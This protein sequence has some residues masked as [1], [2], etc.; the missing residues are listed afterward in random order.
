[1]RIGFLLNHYYL[2]Q[3][4]H[5]VPYAFEL[6]RSYPDYE[7]TIFSST[8]EEETYA[9]DIGRLYPGHR[10]KFE[11][12]EIP[13]W[14][15]ALEPAVRN[16]F[17]LRKEF[18]LRA[19]IRRFSKLDAIVSP[20]MTCLSLRKHLCLKHLKLIFTGHGAGDNRKIGSFDQRISKFDLALL[21]GKKYASALLELGYL[22]AGQYAIAGYPKFEVTRKMGNGGRPLFKNERPVVIY[23]PHHAPH[24]T[25]WHKFGCDVLD[26]FL[27][28]KDYNLIFAPHVVLFERAWSQGAR[29]PRKYVSTDNV[30]IDLGSR[31]STDMTYARASDIYLGD[32]SSQVYEFIET[33]RPCV[34][35]NAQTPDWQGDPSYRHWSFGPVIDNIADMPAALIDAS[36]NFETYSAQQRR[37]FQET[38]GAVDATSAR[39]GADIISRYLENA[40]ASEETQVQ[41]SMLSQV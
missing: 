13:F 24:M 32:N 3:V 21:P 17:F 6:S 23:N 35:L 7:L 11:A 2:H 1:M 27:D 26:F 15:K 41:S 34:F 39:R 14:V 20:E 18:A 19:N 9:R 31:A 10:V 8:P 12:L 29:F 22:T 25:S 37:G 28:S 5:V 38:F 36:A 16:F 30:L 33:P 4:P 40:A